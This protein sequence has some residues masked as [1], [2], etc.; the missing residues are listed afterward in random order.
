[1]TMWVLKNQIELLEM[2]NVTEAK[3]SMNWLNDRFDTA[4]ERFNELEHRIE[5]YSHNVT[6]ND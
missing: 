1:M 4:E 5:K 2:K 6:Q 3:N